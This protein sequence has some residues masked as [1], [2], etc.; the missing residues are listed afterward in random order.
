MTL[1][2]AAGAGSRTG[3]LVAEIARHR[4][5]SVRALDALSLEEIGS[6]IDLYFEDA[7]GAKGKRKVLEILRGHPREAR[8]R[9]EGLERF[10]RALEQSI[11]TVER[12]L[13][14]AEGR[15]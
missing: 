9:R 13:A 2:A 4:G 15:A 5:H 6:V 8:R 11:A 10:E 12:L 3:H 1:V 7:T 14:E